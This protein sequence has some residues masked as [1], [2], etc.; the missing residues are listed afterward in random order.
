MSV[1]APSFARDDDKMIGMGQ[2]MLV[3]QIENAL[4]RRGIDS[5]GI[6][7]LTLAEVVELKNVLSSSDTNTVTMNSNARQILQSAANR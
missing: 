1:A 2:A 7:N 5:T 3:G 4:S 6:E